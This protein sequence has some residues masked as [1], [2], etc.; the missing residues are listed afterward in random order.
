LHNGN[1]AAHLPQ[2]ANAKTGEADYLHQSM[3]GN[4]TIKP[5]RSTSEQVLEIKKF[6]LKRNF[7]S[8]G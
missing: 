2:P 7:I 5:L 6:A 3:N 1:I 8:C 4:D